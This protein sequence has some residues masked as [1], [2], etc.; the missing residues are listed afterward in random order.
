MA[1]HEDGPVVLALADDHATLTLG[2]L[3]AHCISQALQGP[4]GLT[5]LLRGGLGSGKTTFVRGLV[6]AL[7]GG[8]D[9]EV[10]SP[11][12]NIV[13]IYP[14]EPETAHMDLYRL[15]G[16]VTDE[17]VEEH[18]D[19]EGTGERGRGRLVLVEWAQFIPPDLLP[20][21]A[22]SFDWRP[23]GA[24]REVVVAAAGETAKRVF[25]LLAPRLG[26]AGTP[27]P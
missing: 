19:P 10:S 22:L 2:A 5:L 11:S 13:N 24:G 6:S 9:A 18:L 3:T 17:T 23:C 27:L 1:L 21:D 20:G 14:T 4:S 12:F 25:T 7:P 26:E 16:M 15:E 8:R